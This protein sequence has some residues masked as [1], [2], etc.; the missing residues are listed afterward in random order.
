MD[1]Y[2]SLYNRSISAQLSISSLVLPF[3]KDDHKLFPSDYK[4]Y[5]VT[6]KYNDQQIVTNYYSQKEP[7]ASEVFQYIFILGTCVYKMNFLDF[8]VKFGC[9]IDSIK[10]RNKYKECK[11]MGKKL[12]QLIG[13]S[14]Y[15]ELMQN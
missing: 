8:C 1:G 4:R 11:K 6:L 5:L 7:T 10:V 9:D 2:E 15:E 14:Q 13:A 3:K 12:Q